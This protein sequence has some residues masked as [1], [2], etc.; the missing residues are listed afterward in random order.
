M[1]GKATANGPPP[2]QTNGTA[3]AGKGAAAAGQPAAKSKPAKN[4][5]RSAPI[6]GARRPA[7]IHTHPPTAPCG[8]SKL[9]SNGVP[10]RAE[11]SQRK[12]LA[13]ASAPKAGAASAKPTPAKAV[14]RKSPGESGAK[15]PEKAGPGK[16][17]QLKAVRKTPVPTMALVPK[18]ASVK[19]EKP[20]SANPSRPPVPGT[21]YTTLAST[22][23]LTSNKSAMA[24]PK[25]TAPPGGQASAVPQQQKNTAASAKKDLVRAAPISRARLA[26]SNPALDK[27][28]GPAKTAKAKLLAEPKAKSHTLPATPKGLEKPGPPGPKTSPKAGGSRPA[29]PQR[30]VTSTP[31]RLIAG[32]P[33]KKPPKKEASYNL[34]PVP[35]PRKKLLSPGQGE[36]KEA[37]ANVLVAS[38]D[39]LP[40]MERA[41]LEGGVRPLDEQGLTPEVGPVLPKPVPADKDAPKSYWLEVLGVE[42]TPARD[43]E[44]MGG[45]GAPQEGGGSSGPE[46]VMAD[47]LSHQESCPGDQQLTGFSPPRGVGSPPREMLPTAGTWGPKPAGTELPDVMFTPQ[48]EQSLVDTSA[49][50][51]D[52]CETGLAA[53]GEPL[54][55]Q[56]A[57]MPAEHLDLW[58]EGKGRA[59]QDV[60]CLAPAQLNSSCPAGASQ[61]LPLSKEIPWG[62]T[63]GWQPPCMSP[64]HLAEPLQGG[65]REEEMPAQP[66]AEWST[67]ETDSLPW[68]GLEGLCPEDVAEPGAV[69]LREEWD[70]SLSLTLPGRGQETQD[71]LTLERGTQGARR[72]SGKM[73]DLDAEGVTS[74]EAVA[75]SQGIEGLS[76]EPV[77]AGH[78]PGEAASPT[79]QLREDSKGPEDQPSLTSPPGMS[80]SGAGGSLPVELAGVTLR[81]PEE[82]ELGYA[83]L[84]SP[85]DVAKVGSA[86]GEPPLKGGADVLE[87][88]EPHAQQ[89]SPLGPEVTMHKPQSLPLKSMELPQELAQCPP[90]LGQLSSSSA[91]S[92]ERL[93]DGPSRSSTLSG[94]DL[95]G[96]SSSETSTPEELRDYDSSSGVES[97]SD[98]KLEQ[99]FPHSPLEDLMGEQDLGIHMD[100]GDDEAETLPVDKLLGDLPTVSSEDEGELDGDLLK[101]PDFP[102]TGK[103]L[104]CRAA[105]P[106][107]KPYLEESEELGSGDAGTGTPASTNSA[108]SFD[109]TF[110]L[111]S[112]DSCGKSP[113]LSSLE[114]EEHSTENTRDQ[115][116]KGSEPASLP[117]VEE[118]SKISL[119]GDWGC[120]C[121]LERPLQMGPV[122]EEEPTSQPYGTAPRGPAAGESGA[123]L[124]PF[125]WGPCPP[126]ILSTIYE[127][128]GGAE[129]PGQVP[130]EEEDG[131]CQLLPAAPRDK[132]PLHLGS[133]QATVMQQLISRT[134]LFSTTGE[135]PVGGRGAP[136]MNE[137]ELGKWTDLLSPLDESRASIT[138]VT[139]FS[140][141]DVSSPQGD[142]TVVEVET[143]H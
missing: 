50:L 143:F 8:G 38:P 104:V 115:I 110:H 95:A 18:L 61:M 77:C 41:A 84:G 46:L 27:I 34:E 22:R 117:E 103:P 106:P 29:T 13:A 51:L 55:C 124:G 43:L 98:E 118:H 85:G 1:D 6:S 21:E 39:A 89:G 45:G 75:A 137:V 53:Q 99:A 68:V 139:S 111:H 63:G 47:P 97:K 134:L 87:D 64:K 14:A 116:P 125:S 108:T 74:T 69:E 138:S 2:P 20:E 16:A 133:L 100:K 131:S 82:A 28:A 56:E 121:Q 120:G 122:D 88:P 102:V 40:G 107:G 101:E 119:P 65:E 135:M 92:E 42:Q 123:G 71:A 90:H 60:T 49:M 48:A 4:A 58:L 72:G 109:A 31:K 83:C 130:E 54:P 114:S 3:T 112:S 141:E 78:E 70:G 26:G 140:P 79:E 33:G 105:S 132:A 136:V 11:A 62:G 52:P 19:P 17:G 142:W 94:P 76:G 129:T 66:E 32:S 5:V 59:V 30:V 15:P 12:P 35:V 24:K 23:A 86:E 10:P 44:G 9:L 7:T 73:E 36:A 113:G 37:A 25:Q 67:H 81:S 91:E 126:E 57:L 93:L 127:V 80:L 128:E 96:K